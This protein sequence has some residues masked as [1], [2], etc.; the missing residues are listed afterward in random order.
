VCLQILSHHGVG[1]AGQGQQR[2]LIK[3]QHMRQLT[4]HMRGRH[5][6]VHLD[7]EEVLGANGGAILLY[8]FV[9]EAAQGEVSSV[10]SLFDDFS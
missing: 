2:I 8:N 5:T 1:R 7:I 10:A 4:E 6:V 3:L 9:G